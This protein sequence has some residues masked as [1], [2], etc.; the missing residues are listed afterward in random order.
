MPFPSPE[1]TPPVT[2]M[3]FV[4]SLTTGPDCSRGWRAVAC[5]GSTTSPIGG[6]VV[7]MR[8]CNRLARTGGLSQQLLRMRGAVLGTLETGEHA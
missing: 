1:A 8:S 5:G 3:Y 6:C 2:K 4:R 7:P